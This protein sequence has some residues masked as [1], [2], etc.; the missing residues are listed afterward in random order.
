[1]T[2]L[3]DQQQHSSPSGAM[4]EGI[5]VASRHLVREL[6]FLHDGLAGTDLPPSAVHALI[7]LDACDGITAKDLGDRLHLEKSS[8]SRM[9]RKLIDSGDVCETP[10]RRD[11]RTKTLSLT[12]SGR[13]RVSAIHAFA[14]AQVV[15]ALSHL[16]PE[17]QQT[18]LSGLDLYGTALSAPRTPGPTLTIASGYRTG[19]IARITEMHA[20]YYART[21]GFGAVFESVVAG[22]LAAF[23][24]RLSSPCNGVW[25][26]LLDGRMVG[27]VAVDG[28]DL[29]EGIA[30]LRWF[31]MD[32]CA[33]GSGAGRRLLETALEF[34]DSRRVRETHLWTF[35]GL[36]AARH[37]YESCGFRCVEERPGR[38]WGREVLEQRFVR[39]A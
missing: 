13:R 38:Q 16:T 6:G 29:G 32:D 8:I 20:Q 33:R 11:G 5:R 14:R 28:E 19:M 34:V 22:G 1:M 17:E 36:A 15:Q 25:L 10:G 24:P 35:A 31:I 18:V 9:L 3:P 30:H 7:D 37:L 21:S 2:P 39:A 27:S 26:A 12:A 4:V 23:C